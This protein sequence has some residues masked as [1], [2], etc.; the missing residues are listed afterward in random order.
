M[1]GDR[2]N[3]LSNKVARN[4]QFA[5]AHDRHRN[6][7]EAR[8]SASDLCHGRDLSPR[9]FAAA[10]SSDVGARTNGWGTW[11]LRLEYR[12]P[13]RA[14]RNMSQATTN[15][16]RVAILVGCDNTTPDLLEHALKLVALGFWRTPS[17]ARTIRRSC[18]AALS[19]QR[20]LWP[21]LRLPAHQDRSQ[22]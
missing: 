2:H 7:E 8:N 15:E 11:R 6:A 20:A 21:R 16:L 9:R 22:Q 13:E 12:C 4:P 17:Q 18:S 10:I 14:T 19:S 5:C 1:E 3:G